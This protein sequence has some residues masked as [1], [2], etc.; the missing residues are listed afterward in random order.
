MVEGGFNSAPTPF[1]ASSPNP[2]GSPDDDVGSFSHE[3]FQ[4]QTSLDGELFK[5][6]PAPDFYSDPTASEVRSRA[7]ARG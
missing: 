7:P 1:A 3:L 6:L 5:G 4:G 2:G